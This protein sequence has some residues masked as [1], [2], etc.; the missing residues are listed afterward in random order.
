MSAATGVVEEAVLLLRAAPS[1]PVRH[2]LPRP[3]H[4]W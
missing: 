2:S 1:T 4:G 3:D